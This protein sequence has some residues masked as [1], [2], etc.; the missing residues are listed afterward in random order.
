MQ[1]ATDE[2]MVS[3]SVI[4]SGALIAGY[5]IA[6][7]QRL[8]R[9]AKSREHELLV[10]GFAWR[11]RHAKKAGYKAG[12]RDGFTRGRNATHPPDEDVD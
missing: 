8:R 2:P 9:N 5:A 3:A 11:E 6:V 7:A 12:Y 10:D 4:V 1:S